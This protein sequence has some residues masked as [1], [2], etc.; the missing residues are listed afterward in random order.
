[1]TFSL[2]VVKMLNVS[3]LFIGFFFFRSTEELNKLYDEELH[4]I[5][6]CLRVNPKSYGTWDHRTFVMSNIPQAD[7]KRELF[8]CNK[9]LEY[10]ER[11][12]KYGLFL[13][14]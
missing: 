2:N 5:E 14:F 3:C 7:W 13:K 4:F 10:D 9:F 1:M 11:N 12:C 8:L 6:S